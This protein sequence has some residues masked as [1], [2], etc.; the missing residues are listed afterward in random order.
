M[1][2]GFVSGALLNAW[3]TRTDPVDVEACFSYL[4]GVFDSLSAIHT[5]SPEHPGAGVNLD[6]IPDRVSVTELRTVFRR[7]VAG[8]PESL[9]V[10][11]TVV[12]LEAWAENYEC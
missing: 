5:A 4:R 2:R 11:A 3:C 10:Q 6:C 12:V 7:Y 9:A 1:V 8:H